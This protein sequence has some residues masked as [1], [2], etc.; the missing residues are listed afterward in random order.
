MVGRLDSRGCWL[1]LFV[2]RTGGC[3]VRLPFD[4]Y[5][6]QLQLASSAEPSPKLWRQPLQLL[7]LAQRCVLHLLASPAPFLIS[8]AGLASSFRP[9]TSTLLTSLQTH[10]CNVALSRDPRFVF[11]SSS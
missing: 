5:W 1:K 7:L 9:W 4:L 10:K 2:V 8:T 11:Q 6:H 3:S